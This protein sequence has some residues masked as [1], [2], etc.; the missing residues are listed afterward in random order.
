MATA[1]RNSEF[2]EGSARN[3]LQPVQ[4]ALPFPAPTRY[5]FRELS[6]QIVGGLEF[7]YKDP[8]LAKPVPAGGIAEVVANILNPGAPAAA[9]MAAATAPGLAQETPLDLNIHGDSAYVVLQLDPEL[10]WRFD[11]D[12][13]AVSLKDGRVADHYGGL[14]HV[15]ADGTVQIDPAIDCKLVYFAA[16]PPVLAPGEDYRHGLN[17]HIELVQNSPSATSPDTILPIILDPDVGHPG[18]SQS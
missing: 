18:G 16:K 4:A 8:S 13:A 12:E 15:L 3:N 1:L 10:N 11:S 9:V 17:F 14:R 6:M 2:I 7:F 5:I